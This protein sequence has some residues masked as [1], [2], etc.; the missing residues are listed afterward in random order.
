MALARIEQ[1]LKIAIFLIVT[2]C[3]LEYSQ[4]KHARVPKPAHL[5][6]IEI[7]DR[8]INIVIPAVGLTGRQ[9]ERKKELIAGLAQEVDKQGNL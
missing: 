8:P 9:L 2:L 6:L 7:K 4:E 5:D 3:T 1:Y